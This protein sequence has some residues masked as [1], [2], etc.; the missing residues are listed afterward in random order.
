[1]PHRT[2]GRRAPITPD[3]AV[4]AAV[5]LERATAADH[6]WLAA[7]ARRKLGELHDEVGAVLIRPAAVRTGT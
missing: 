6:P 1:M 5:A 3:R 4:A 7:L 2:R